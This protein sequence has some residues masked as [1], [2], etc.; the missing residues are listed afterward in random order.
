VDTAPAAEEPAAAD[1]DDSGE[2]PAEQAPAEA[3]PEQPR[4]HEQPQG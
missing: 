1:G 4:A 2:A 3:P